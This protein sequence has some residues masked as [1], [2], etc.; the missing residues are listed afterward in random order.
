MVPKTV[1]DDRQKVI[2]MCDVNSKTFFRKKNKFSKVI[3]K[4]HMFLFE[5]LKTK[6][7]SLVCG[8][9]RFDYD[10]VLKINP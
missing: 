4:S 5:T 3:L 2:T 1:S 6:V 10:D 7:Y 8:V 9:K